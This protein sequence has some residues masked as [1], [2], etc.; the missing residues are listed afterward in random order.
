MKEYQQNSNQTGGYPEKRGTLSC[1]DGTSNVTIQ[2]DEVIDILKT[3]EGL[4]RKLQPLL[5]A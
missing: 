2:K 4:K 3:L 1:T 5:K